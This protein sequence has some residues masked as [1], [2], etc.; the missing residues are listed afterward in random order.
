[1]YGEKQVNCFGFPGKL[2]FWAEESVFNT[3]GNREAL[4]PNLIPFDS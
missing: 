2:R 3:A 1:M 4:K